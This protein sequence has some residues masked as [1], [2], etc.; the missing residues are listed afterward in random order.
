MKVKNIIKTTILTSTMLTIF[1]GC[2]MDEI[3]RKYSPEGVT[4]M[5]QDKM[6][7]RSADNLLKDFQEPT[8]AKP[9]VKFYDMPRHSLSYN[10]TTITLTNQWVHFSENVYMNEVNSYIADHSADNEFAK[11]YKEAVKSRG[12]EYKKFTAPFNK[13]VAEKMYGRA[14]PSFDKSKD[15]RLIWDKIPMLAE[16]NKE[17]ELLSVMIFKVEVGA[18]FNKFNNPHVQSEIILNTII[19]VGSSLNSIKNSISK[20]EWEENQL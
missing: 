9:F 19:A 16:F 18:A 12:N 1:T 20:K 14:V 17:G 13:K 4:K 15:L 6:S 7:G 11:L 8:L 5:L 10:K 2:A 3:A